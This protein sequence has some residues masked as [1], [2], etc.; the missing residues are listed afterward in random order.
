[1]VGWR[2]R[3]FVTSSNSFYSFIYLGYINCL[4][5]SFF[6]NFLCGPFFKIFVEFVTILLLLYIYIYIWLQGMWDLSSLTRYWTCT[7]CIGRWGPNHWTA[8]EVSLLFILKFLIFCIF[9]HNLL[10]TCILFL[11][12]ILL[13]WSELLK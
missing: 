12:Y 13:S 8:K 4:V 7:P 2:W 6:F 1:M 10:N 5:Y 3:L 9:H 11:F